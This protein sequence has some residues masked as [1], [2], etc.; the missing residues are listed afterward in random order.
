MFYLQIWVLWEINQD[1]KI[2]WIFF[3]VNPQDFYDLKASNIRMIFQFILYNEV[4]DQ[5]KYE[6]SIW[7]EEW[8]AVK[9]SK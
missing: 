4:E 5:A 1:F 2:D 3:S 9:I 8:A 7:I 6:A